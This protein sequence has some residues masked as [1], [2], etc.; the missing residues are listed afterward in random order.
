MFRMKSGL[1]V[2]LVRASSA[3]LKCRGKEAGVALQALMAQV[4]K[5]V[6]RIFMIVVTEKDG[7]VLTSFVEEMIKVVGVVPH[8]PTR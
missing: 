7:E 2:T 3:S 5:F 4:K 1:N 6:V 8:I